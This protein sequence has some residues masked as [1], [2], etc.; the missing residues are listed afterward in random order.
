MEE[1]N[2]NVVQ[3]GPDI[4]KRIEVSKSIAIH[5]EDEPQ[6]KKSICSKGR[7]VAD[8]NFPTSIHHRYSILSKTNPKLSS[9]IKAITQ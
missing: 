9:C 1:E 2:N 5:M 6:W 7:Y 3:H 4:H 8:K